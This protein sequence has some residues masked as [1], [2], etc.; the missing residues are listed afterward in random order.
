MYFIDP[1]SKDYTLFWQTLTAYRQTSLF[2]LFEKCKLA[3]LINTL[4]QKDRDAQIICFHIGWDINYGTRML[5]CF[6]KIGLL[7]YKNAYY[8]LSEFSSCFFLKTSPY[9]QS[10]S[11][12]FER[13]LEHS[14]D[15]LESVLVAGKRVFNVEDKS[16]YDLKN[17]QNF[18]IG[19]MDDA[20]NIRA[21][22]L[23]SNFEFEGKG[24]ILDFGAGSGAYLI[25]FL[26][27]FN[28]WDAIFCDLD[29]IVEM[30]RN[31]SRLKAFG[32]RIRYYG[33]NLLDADFQDDPA[34]LT[35][36]DII[37]LSNFIHCYDDNA[38]QMIF[39]KISSFCN[40]DTTVVVHDFFK[41]LN[42]QG[43]IYD[44]HMMLNTY[45]GQVYTTNQVIDNL[46]LVGFNDFRIVV[47][48]SKSAAIIAKRLKINNK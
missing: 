47:C 21:Q 36:L 38:L 1:S 32:N 41:D 31:N 23:L 35:N 4:P 28:N 18:F 25:Y 26:S 44:I 43:A 8:N 30:A 2:Y 24:T 33:C 5:D 39:K 17:F 11:I 29:D 14:W 37:L 16:N 42:F 46:K 9:N 27:K 15:T 3:D 34:Q 6:C 40:K 45:S 10:R 19:A 7:E 22:E 20:A 48:P 12:Q 13:F